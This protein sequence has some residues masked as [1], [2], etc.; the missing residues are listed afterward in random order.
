M[1]KR[2][3]AVSTVSGELITASAL[4]GKAADRVATPTVAAEVVVEPTFVHVLNNPST[5]QPL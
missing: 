3:L 5:S 2:Y 4:A 1:N